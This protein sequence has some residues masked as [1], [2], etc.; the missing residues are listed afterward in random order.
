[1][2]TPGFVASVLIATSIALAGCVSPV[3]SD[4]TAS[5][6]AGT[7]WSLVQMTSMDDAQPP[8]RPS[9]SGRYTLSF[10]ADGRASMM[11]DCNR[12]NS[13]W[14]STGNGE[15]GSIAFG[16]IATTRVMCPPASIGDRLARQL[17]DVRGYRLQNGNLHLSLM[18]DAGILTW[19]PVNA[20]S[21]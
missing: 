21:R 4:S 18:A 13:T 10:S 17:A 19:E 9:D 8:V 2:S 15:A 1:M 16:P 11:L 7:Q 12:G 14:T 3:A 20:V 5:P 6:L